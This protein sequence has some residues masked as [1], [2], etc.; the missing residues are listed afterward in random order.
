MKSSYTFAQGYLHAHRRIKKIKGFYA[1]LLATVLIIPFLTFINLKL[2]PEFHWFWFA[3]AG[4]LIG[5]FLHWFGVFGF[6]KIGLGKNWEKKRIDQIMN[7][8]NQTK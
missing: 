4:M 7:E 6:E 3:V 1:Q 2:A 8:S 5:L